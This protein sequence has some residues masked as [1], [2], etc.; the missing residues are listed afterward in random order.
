MDEIRP[1]KAIPIRPDVHVTYME[2]SVKS[3]GEMITIGYDDGNIEL[4]MNGNFDKCMSIKYHD[5]NDKSV[6]NG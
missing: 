6:Y 3:Y 4:V 2:H 5:G 1:L